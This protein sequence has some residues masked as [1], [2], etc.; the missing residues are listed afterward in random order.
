M[1]LDLGYVYTD[2]MRVLAKNVAPRVMGE[3]AV[4]E[5]ATGWMA[6]RVSPPTG[7]ER[8][9]DGRRAANYSFTMICGF[10]DEGGAPVTLREQDRVEIE[11]G[12]IPFTPFGKF[13]ITSVMVPRD[14]AQELLQVA[15]L[16]QRKEY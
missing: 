7:T 11:S 16:T 4:Y 1:P 3:G 14:L 15:T 8:K 2:R 5:V 9:S 10:T 6:C 12:P 13:D